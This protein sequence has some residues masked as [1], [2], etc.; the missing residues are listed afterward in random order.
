MLL[1]W[2]SVEAREKTNWFIYTLRHRNTHSCPL[3]QSC[4]FKYAYPKPSLATQHFQAKALNSPNVP[5]PNHE[6]GIFSLKNMNKSEFALHLISIYKAFRTDVL[7]PFLTIIKA[8]NIFKK[9]EKKMPAKFT[10]F[11][12][13]T[14]G[15]DDL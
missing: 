7:Q 10:L 2:N 8:K 5:L 9:Q 11:Y 13:M 6:N 15:A 14:P 3:I 12:T 4:C 1:I